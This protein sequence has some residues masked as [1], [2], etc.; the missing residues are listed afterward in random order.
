MTEPVPAEITAASLVPLMV[1]TTD[2]VVPSVGANGEGLGQRLAGAE[3]LD[4]RVGVGGGVGPDAV[5]AQ[6]EGAVGAG[7]GG[8][9]LEARLGR[10]GV[11]DGQRATGGDVAADHCRRPR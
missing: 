5:G 1:T 4:G 7:G 6:R 10:I 2:E 11:R 9:S 3:G 8:L